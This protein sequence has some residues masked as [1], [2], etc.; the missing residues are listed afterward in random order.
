MLKAGGAVLI[1][2]ALTACGSL[3]ASELK[4]RARLLGAMTAALEI[5]RMEIVSRLAPLPEVCGRLAETGPVE[6]RQLFSALCRRLPELGARSFADIWTE[7]AA[8]LPLKSGELA[9][10]CDLGGALGRYGAEEQGA[11]IERCME[12][13][14][15]AAR[16]AGAEAV[17]GGR[18]ST[19]VGLTAGLI[20]AVMLI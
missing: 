14:S 12:I 19:G 16:E 17:S 3:R 20:L 15:L 1:I 13:L 7:E 18:L 6:A 2:I 4:F 10:L 9:A 11:A 8:A 5:M